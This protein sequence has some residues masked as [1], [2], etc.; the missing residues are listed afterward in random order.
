MLIKLDSARYSLRVF[1]KDTAGTSIDR[2]IS[3]VPGTSILL[4]AIDAKVNKADPKASIS[5]LY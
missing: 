1:A 2:T 5:K 4:E 3:R